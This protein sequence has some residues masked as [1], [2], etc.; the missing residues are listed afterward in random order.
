D[1]VEV[2]AG[3]D[4]GHRGEVQ[5][6]IRKRRKDGSYDP[7]RVYVVVAGANLVIKHQ[8]RSPSVRT[9][10]GRIE[11]EAPIHIS[12]V[13]LVG[14]DGKPTRAGYRIEGEDKIRI[15]RRSGDP[16]AKPDNS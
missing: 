3:N 7:N 14:T 8:G 13:L 12:N 2:I 11:R 15:D 10:T 1:T 16:L 9:Q 5:R 6:V 4:K